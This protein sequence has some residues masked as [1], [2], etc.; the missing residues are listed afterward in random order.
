MKY[1]SEGWGTD[2]EC[3][4]C[5]ELTFSESTYYPEINEDLRFMGWLTKRIKGEW[6]DFCCQI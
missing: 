3:D 5:G 6:L 1:I 4:T 2:I